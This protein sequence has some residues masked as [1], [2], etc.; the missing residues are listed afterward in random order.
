[1]LL[2]IPPQS[3]SRWATSWPSER[4][5]SAASATAALASSETVG[6]AA[7]RG[8]AVDQ[9]TR[10]LPGAVFADSTKGRSGGGGAPASSEPPAI[11]SSQ[12]AVSRTERLTQPST[13]EP[14]PALQVGRQRD[15][16]PLR[17]QAE[18]AAG[19][20]GD[21]DRPAAVAGRGDRDQAG[22]DR[23]GAAA[24]GAPG[25]RCGFQG[26]RVTP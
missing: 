14:V 10:S 19:G 6:G 23:R 25:V 26:L 8:A 13:D 15:P 2:P 5:S 3:G 11:T 16:A 9:A 24:A 21:A 12:S 4:S 20:G 17:L 22:G 18:Q 7:A 1:M